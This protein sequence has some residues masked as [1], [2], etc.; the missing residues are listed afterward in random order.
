MTNRFCF[1]FHKNT[2]GDKPRI[3]QKFFFLPLLSGLFIGTSYIPFPPWAI[4]FGYVPLWLFALNQK[5]LADLI[6][7]A[8]LCQLILTLI[9]FNYLLGAFQEMGFPFYQALLLFLVFCSVANWS[10]PLSLVIWFFF[11]KAIQKTKLAPPFCILFFLPVGLGLCTEYSPML[12]D[13]HLGY[14]YFYAKWPLAQTAEIWGFR[15]LHTLTLFS[16]LIFLK[17]YVYWFDWT[18][19]K[20]GTW[21]SSFRFGLCRKASIILLGGWLFCM[22]CLNGYGQYLKNRLPKPDQKIRVLM[23]QPDIK[24]HQQDDKKSQ[25]VV[26][27]QILQE[28]SKHFYPKA[29]LAHSDK[30]TQYAILNKARLL[31]LK[32]DFILWPEGAYPYPI[33]PRLAKKGQDP[34]QK[35]VSVFNTAL[36]V[37]AKGLYIK[38]PEPVKTDRENKIVPP[39]QAKPSPKETTYTNSIFVFDKKSKLVQAP[40]NKTLL[41]PIGEYTPGAKWFPF[42]DK[43]LFG[44][45]S[46]TF[47]KGQG[48]HKTA[49]L[50][51]YSLGFH[52]CYEGLF[53][54]VS[55]DLIREG[56]DLIINVANT[57]YFSKRQAPY[58]LA[59]MTLSRAIETRRPVIH[60]ANSGPSAIVSAKGDILSFK[61]FGVQSGL[62]EIPL[63]SKEHQANTVF[64]SYG[65]YINQVFLW[66]CMLIIL[67]KLAQLRH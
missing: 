60:G 28:T 9:G 40:Y 3:T 21:F 64:V 34:I 33:H 56:A 59:Y 23:I 15:F 39:S 2:K 65:Y 63:H 52:I 54:H 8:W 19:A 38:A 17:L 12:F 31:T 37:S 61:D 42:I 10:I 5:K 14:V 51:Q 57:A 1:I 47:K 46:K 13:W 53:D 27:S 67:L 26:L 18:P 43:W 32:P 62:E 48:Q 6:T 50:G 24:N 25:P 36:V 66:L 41:T 44:Q 55:R 4:F 16:N 35:W 22:T 30:K 29:P 7:G 49:P 20:V 58:Q 11:R 45:H